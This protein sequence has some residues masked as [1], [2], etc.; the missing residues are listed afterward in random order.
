MRTEELESP[1]LTHGSE[2]GLRNMSKA[3]SE[4][5]NFRA[6]KGQSMVPELKRDTHLVSTAE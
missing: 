4:A 1:W 6:A 3:A 5:Q 2:G